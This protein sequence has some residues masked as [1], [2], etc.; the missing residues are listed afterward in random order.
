MLPD[1][2]RPPGAEREPERELALALCHERYEQIDD[3]RAA[4]EEEKSRRGEEHY[5]RRSY[6]ADE[7]I[8][9]RNDMRVVDPRL[10]AVALLERF[11]DRARLAPR[12]R[13]RDPLA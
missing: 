1:E 11:R 9:Q 12:L 8:A 6:V 10:V 7:L 4:D 2:T 5:E 3:V 13:E